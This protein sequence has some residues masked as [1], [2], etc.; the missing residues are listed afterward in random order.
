MQWLLRMPQELKILAHQES[1]GML[2]MYAT[3]RLMTVIAAHFNARFFELTSEAY[4]RGIE[5]LGMSV[6]TQTCTHVLSS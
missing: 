3:P 1:T 6:R 2:H 5:E 4:A